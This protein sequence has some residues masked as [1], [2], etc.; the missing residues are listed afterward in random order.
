MLSDV[1]VPRMSLSHQ[2]RVAIGIGFGV[3]LGI[4]LFLFLFYL[5]FGRRGA[6]HAADD[7]AHELTSVPFGSASGRNPDPNHAPVR[8]T[9]QSFSEINA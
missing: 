4:L 2:A 3:G 5:L 8:G 9:H 1:L 6:H 7:D